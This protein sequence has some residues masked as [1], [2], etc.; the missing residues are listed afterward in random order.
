MERTSSG[1]F[2]VTSKRKLSVGEE[3]YQV[4][5]RRSSFGGEDDLDVEEENEGGEVSEE[6]LSSP[7]SKQKRKKAPNN[8]GKVNKHPRVRLDASGLCAPA[9][10]SEEV[11][12]PVNKGVVE[13]EIEVKVPHN[14]VNEVKGK[15]ARKVS[16]EEETPPSSEVRR[17][18]RG[19]KA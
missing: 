8:K 1:S 6:G 13:E 19:V 14:K 4:H 18:K 10:V 15:R 11:C 7:R 9:V 16:M 5:M 3:L 2:K 17:S 12:A